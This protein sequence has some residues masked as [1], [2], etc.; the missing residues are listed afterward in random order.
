MATSSDS[1]TN[2]A[3]TIANLTIT[4]NDLSDLIK[5]QGALVRKLKEEKASTEQ[6]WYLIIIEINKSKENYLN[7]SMKLLQNYLA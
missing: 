3:S 1:T 4:D 5:I 6:V 2:L 7:R